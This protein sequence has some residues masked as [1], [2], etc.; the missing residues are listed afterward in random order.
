M[1]DKTDRRAALKSALFDLLLDVVKN[2][3]VVSIT[4]KET[5]DV[6]HAR[7]T[8]DA[9]ILNVARQLVKDFQDDAEQPKLG[10]GAPQ[11][12]LAKH[13]KDLPFPTKAN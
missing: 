12:V 3:K 9:A 2:G 13:L 7:V 10:S 5:G 11:G 8:P 1:T 6:E 4:D